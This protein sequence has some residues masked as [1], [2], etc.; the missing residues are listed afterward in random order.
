MGPV[1]VSQTSCA[2]KVSQET[3]NKTAQARA[4]RFYKS[5][6]SYEGHSVHSSETKPEVSPE[7]FCSGKTNRKGEKAQV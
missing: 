2:L 1:R 7:P 3:G 5:L 6:I 4:Q